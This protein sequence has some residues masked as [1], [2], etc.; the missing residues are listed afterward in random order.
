[1][2]FSPRRDRTSLALS[3]L[4]YLLAIL[5]PALPT[6][7]F[8]APSGWVGGSCP[9]PPH[10]A[11]THHLSSLKLQLGCSRTPPRSLLTQSR[12]SLSAISPLF[13]IGEDEGLSSSE[14][15][16]IIDGTDRDSSPDHNIAAVDTLS[17]SF[18]ASSMRIFNLALLLSALSYLLYSVLHVDS[19]IARGWTL[20]EQVGRM[21]YDNWRNYEGS[22]EVSDSS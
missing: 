6:S 4:L 22:L 3:S 17:P 8:V 14:N 19:D 15:S 7:S 2:G 11:D 10:G 16:S 13:A 9:Q 5:L 12:A 1:M 21:P 18:T 20:A